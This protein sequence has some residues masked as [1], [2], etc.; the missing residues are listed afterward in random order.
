MSEKERPASEA[1]EID[2]FLAELE[3]GGEVKDIAGWETGFS[4]L[5]RVLNGISP[6]LYLLIAPPAS[7]KSAFVKQLLDQVARHNSVPALFFAFAEKKSDLRIRTLARLSG[8]ESRDIRRGAGYLLHTYGAP[9]RR[10]EDPEQ[11]PASWEKLKLAAEAAK[12]WLDLVY[13]CECD[14]KTTLKDVER[15]VRE[16]RQLKKS[17]SLMVVI[18][19][20]QRLG[21]PALSLDARLPLVVERLHDLAIR[22]DLPLLATSP[23][24]VPAAA[25]QQW[26]ERVAGAD[27]IMVMEEAAERTK[28]L[29]EPARAI[30]LHVVKNRGG[31]KG[32]LRFDFSPALSK[33]VEVASDS[34]P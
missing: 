24:L 1:E 27:V 20:S 18:D 28:Q 29:T 8:L 33:F 12:S 22:L 3:S 5:S 4:N 23:E 2:S 21:D 6:G 25:P 26:A 7:G 34:S 30:A 13:I 15:R 31:E 17:Q 19:D 16:L 11:L 9:K 32:T 10:L 14:E